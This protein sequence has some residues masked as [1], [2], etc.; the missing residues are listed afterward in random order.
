MK[1]LIPIFAAI[2]LGIAPLAT[3]AASIEETT[4]KIHLCPSVDEYYEIFAKNNGKTPDQ[5][6]NKE[7]LMLQDLCAAEHKG[8]N[9]GI[10]FDFSQKIDQPAENSELIV[11]FYSNGALT[12]TFK[13]NCEENADLS[14]NLSC[15]ETPDTVKVFLWEKGNLRP[16]CTSKSVLNASSLTQ[17]NAE[18]V[19]LINDGLA[20][21]HV[22]EFYGN[23]RKIINIIKNCAGDAK[24]QA[25]KHLLTSEYV[26]SYYEDDLASAK[27]YYDNLQ[28]SA[29]ADF[30][31]AALKISSTEPGA[32]LIQYLG[33]ESW[34]TETT[35]SAK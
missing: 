21:I 9:T 8:H 7:K 26:K 23:G 14:M 34:L 29:R 24:S 30:Q 11:A 15:T 4:F 2:V 13:L 32:K 6:S 28:G 22:E 12:N 25:D 17:A 5:L 18:L 33:L 16:I 1:K 3:S 35:A 20:E 27:A 19:K 10:W 31:N